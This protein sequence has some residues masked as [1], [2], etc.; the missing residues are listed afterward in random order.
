MP[1]TE[2]PREFLLDSIAPSVARPMLEFALNKN[3]LGQAIYNDQNRR[4]GD[5]YTGGDKIPELYKDVSAKIARETT[6]YL[7][8]SP[9]TLYFLSNS[10]ADGIGRVA[11]TAY[12]MPD[13]IKGNKSFN[14]KTD[15]PLMG[16]FFGAKSNVDSREFSTVEN[17]VKDMER[18]IKMFDKA[19][20][21]TSAQYDVKHPFDRVLVEMY[22]HQLN[23]ELNPLREEAKRIRLMQGITPDTKAAMLKIMTFQENLVKR[24]MI[25]QFKAFD[26]RP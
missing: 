23:A 1:A 9:N 16:S 19:D 11:E 2:M 18:K 10:Y 3:G 8:I 13:I 17:K 25:E 7:D 20:P 22:N 15:L 5:A 26:V 12:G 4:M 14:P 21:L 24:N 6:G